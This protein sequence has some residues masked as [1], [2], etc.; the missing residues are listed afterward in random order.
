M[1]G[2]VCGL[3]L[4]D[5]P[6]RLSGTSVHRLCGPSRSLFAC[7]SALR[8]QRASAH[9]LKKTSFLCF[10]VSID[11]SRPA[12]LHCR[13]A[14]TAHFKL[15]ITT[16]VTEFNLAHSFLAELQLWLSSSSLN[17]SS[18]LFPPFISSHLPFL[19]F[20][21]FLSSFLPLSLILSFLS[22]PSLVL[23]LSF[24]L[25]TVHLLFLFILFLTCNHILYSIF[26]SFSI[27]F[28]F[29]PLS[30]LIPAVFFHYL[31]DYLLSI[32]FSSLTSSLSSFIFIRNETLLWASNS[33]H[34][35][36]SPLFFMSHKTGLFTLDLLC[37]CFLFSNAN[38]GFLFLCL[39]FHK[40]LI[41]AII[42]FDK[43]DTRSL[44]NG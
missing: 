25:F 11:W 32:F 16:R 4:F 44:L 40:S 28:P 37:N 7:L 23:L 27:I 1:S 17:V 9:T 20:F 26:L 10:V 13:A 34:D 5:L 3:T 14:K 24:S 41:V 38:F 29:I 8:A 12:G 31:F 18:L 39:L 21:S 33:G 36:I 42:L 15:V 19:F 30:L 43:Y 35:I 2:H 22:V 6:S